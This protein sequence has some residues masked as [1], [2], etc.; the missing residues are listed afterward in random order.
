MNRVATP[1]RSRLSTALL[2]GCVVL[3]LAACSGDPN[4]MRF[5]NSTDRPDEFSVV[6]AQPLAT[7]TDT[8]VLP[9]P[10]PGARNRAEP[11]PV[12]DALLALGGSSAALDRSGIPS[13]DSAV[14]SYAGRF[15]TNATIREQLAEEDLEFRKSRYIR[16]ME[17][18]AS[19]NVYFR[20]YQSQQLDQQAEIDRLR[21]LG[22]RVPSAPP[23][24]LKPN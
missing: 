10:T 9:V 20:A 18:L 17:S 7:P 5:R 4:L 15:G 1:F 19:V 13:G 8:S 22:V 2:G 23:A 16:P 14:V 11:T 3:A 24:E 21:A 6:P 12:N